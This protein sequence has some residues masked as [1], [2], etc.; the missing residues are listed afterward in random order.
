MLMF[1]AIGGIA[2]FALGVVLTDIGAFQKD[3]D[4]RN[5]LR[6]TGN[7]VGH[8]GSIATGTAIVV[9]AIRAEGHSTAIRAIMLILGVA[10]IFK[11]FTLGFTGSFGA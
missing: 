7:L 8:L 1:A 10:I 4:T 6:S 5:T 3:T 9:A 11:M 2:A